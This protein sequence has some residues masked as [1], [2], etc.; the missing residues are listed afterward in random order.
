V[1]CDARCEHFD[2]QAAQQR[3]D[4]LQEQ[5]SDGAAALEAADVER[6]KLQL[7]LGAVASGVDS[8]LP[9]AE[10][11]ASLDATATVAAAAA[12]VVVVAPIV[13]KKPSKPVVAA[14][15][16]NGDDVDYGVSN[17]N[18]DDDSDHDNDN[19]KELLQTRV[20]RDRAVAE[21]NS[22]QQQIDILQ[23]LLEQKQ[24][25]QPQQQQPQP[26]QP[27][28]QHTTPTS[29]SVLTPVRKRTLLGNDSPA[30]QHRPGD[31]ARIRYSYENQKKIIYY[32]FILRH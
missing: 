5:L 1:L 3:A 25:Q 26:Q 22:L 20:E 4:E 15:P 9:L 30:P 32:A 31:L 27:L 12:P 24:S 10:H 2:C 17:G 19:N 18:Y 11:L 8:L 21:R 16:I 7:T 13:E 6:A 23:K 29:A 28:A 14:V